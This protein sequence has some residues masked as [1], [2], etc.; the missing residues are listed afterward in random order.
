MSDPP[1][2]LP[3]VPMMTPERA[4][5]IGRLYQALSDEL[6]ADYPAQA[7]REAQRSQWWLTYAITLA[8]TKGDEAA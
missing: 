2:G 4:R 1:F 6:A 8:Q 5:D 7:A 3:P